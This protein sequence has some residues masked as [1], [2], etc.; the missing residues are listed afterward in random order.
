MLFLS[1]QAFPIERHAETWVSFVFL[2]TKQLSKHRPPES[3]RTVTLSLGSVCKAG[4][5]EDI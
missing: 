2:N 1:F 4:R 5:I 3:E